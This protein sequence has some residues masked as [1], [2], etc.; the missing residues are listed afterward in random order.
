M[1]FSTE[2]GFPRAPSPRELL[3]RGFSPQPGDHPG[4][5]AIPEYQSGPF[6]IVKTTLGIAG[7]VVWHV[8]GLPVPNVRAN[9]PIEMVAENEA[10][11]LFVDRAAAALP[12][13]EL[14]NG[15]APAVIDVCARLDGIPLAIELAAAR[16]RVLAPDQIAARLGDRFDLLVGT[17]H[18][19]LARHQTLRAAMDWSYALLSAAERQ[20][21]NT[22]AVFAGSWTLEAAETVCA[23]SGI[24]AREVLDL[25]SRLVDRSLVLAQPAVGGI[26]RYRFL[27]TIRQYAAQHLELTG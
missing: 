22:L 18:T 20:L 24:E 6:R 2:K 23:G 27:E 19:T 25:T 3:R 10:V 7:E 21:F 4:R 8:P 26:L 12:G 15:T 5:W 9:E 11:R 1:C 17:G 13:F 14:D 16:V